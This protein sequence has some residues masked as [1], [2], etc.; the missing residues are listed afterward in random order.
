[1]QT[2]YLVNSEIEVEL[3]DCCKEDLHN[4]SKKGVDKKA[5][6]GCFSIRSPCDDTQFINYTGT[7]GEPIMFKLVL[8]FILA[9]L[10]RCF[11]TLTQGLLLEGEDTDT[12]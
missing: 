1:M 3:E 12:L 10:A 2:K 7:T 8:L 5:A 4:G 6:N 11:L 9:K